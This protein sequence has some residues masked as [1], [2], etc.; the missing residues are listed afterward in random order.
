MIQRTY[1]AVS[2]LWLADDDT[3]AWQTV[4]PWQCRRSSAVCLRKNDR[5]RRTACSQIADRFKPNTVL[6]A[7]HTIQPSSLHC[8]SSSASFS[9]VHY[10]I[11]SKNEWYRYRSGIRYRPILGPIPWRIW[12]H[13]SVCHNMSANIHPVWQTV[14]KYLTTPQTRHYTTLCNIYAQ[15][16]SCMGDASYCL[17]LSAIR[18]SCWKIFV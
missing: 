5:N 11:N 8:L 18:C 1:E 17:R 4:E 7:F 15:K 6:W 2:V 13:F 10:V 12:N 16:L 9:Y 14:I 3:L